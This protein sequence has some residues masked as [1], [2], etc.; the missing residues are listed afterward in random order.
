MDA[1]EEGSA[2]A[3]HIG[4]AGV[5]QRV[6]LIGIS[7][8]LTVLVDTG[9]AWGFRGDSKGSNTATEILSKKI[10][11]VEMEGQNYKPYQQ[12]QWIQRAYK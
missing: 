6:G 2:A 10:E 3:L 7:R 5:L 9:V 8:T 12:N 11:E 4:A 1:G